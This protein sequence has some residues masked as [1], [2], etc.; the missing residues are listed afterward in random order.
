MPY[1]EAESPSIV[2]PS[3]ERHDDDVRHPM[4][5]DIVVPEIY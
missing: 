1:E 5:P 2:L 3:R 4:P